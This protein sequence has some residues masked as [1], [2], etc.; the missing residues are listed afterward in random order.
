M[1]LKLFTCGIIYLISRNSLIAEPDEIGLLFIFFNFGILANGVI[2]YRVR[3]FEQTTLL[4]YRGLPIS[5]LKR[6]FN[7]SLLYFILLM[8]EFITLIMLE[9]KH[10]ESTTMIQFALCSYSLLSL[11]SEIDMRKNS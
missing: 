11:L 10:I 4:F 9:P 6:F 5:Y 3:E 2:I 1:G 7:Y 8:P